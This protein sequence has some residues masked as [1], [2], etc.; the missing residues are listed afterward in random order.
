MT[1]S[2]SMAQ[3]QKAGGVRIR[4]AASGDV[5]SIGL[6]ERD[7]FADPWGSREFTSAVEAEQAIFL[8]AE[9]SGGVVMGYVIALTVL[10]EAEIL[11]LAVRRGDR[12]AGLGGTL[13]DSVID[14]AVSR[15]A[16]Q[17]FLEVR[18]SNEPAR[19]LYESRGF[20]EV[21]R[22]RGYYR[23]PVEDALVLRLAVQ[24]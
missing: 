23:A 21:S 24:R 1:G 7:S 22:R 14:K 13:L 8:V 18:E 11:N 15:G 16:E 6:I 19:R 2:A 17:I 20:T 10:D 5:L 12:G 9:D 3:R 4:A